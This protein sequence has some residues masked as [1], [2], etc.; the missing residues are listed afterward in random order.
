MDELDQKQGRHLLTDLSIPGRVVK[1]I[2]TYRDH[3]GVGPL[4]L[5]V[6]N[7][8]DLR[9]NDTVGVVL[10]ALKATGHI[11][12]TI[13]ISIRNPDPPPTDP[14]STKHS[15]MP[16]TVMSLWSTLWTGWAALFGTH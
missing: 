1:F 6:T 3:H 7:E 5:D 8:L 9:S 16:V 15:S 2:A 12:F 13:S 4:W 10:E 14:D 11:T